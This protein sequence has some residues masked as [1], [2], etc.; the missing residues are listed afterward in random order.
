MLG[1]FCRKSLPASN[2]PLLNAF[3]LY[4]SVEP[5]LEQLPE[6]ND[7]VHGRPKRNRNGSIHQSMELENGLKYFARL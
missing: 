4:V 6:F 3:R 1:Y 2:L 7:V 5:G